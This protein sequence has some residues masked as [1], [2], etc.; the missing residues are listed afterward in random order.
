MFQKDETQNIRGFP[1]RLYDFLWN[2]V[3][4]FSKKR[5]G[6]SDGNKVISW[7]NVSKMEDTK[8]SLAGC[9]SEGDSPAGGQFVCVSD[10][11]LVQPHSAV[12]FPKQH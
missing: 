11:G 3:S 4:V 12:V 6:L 10:S 9:R 5:H 2:L 7:K 8:R 1:T